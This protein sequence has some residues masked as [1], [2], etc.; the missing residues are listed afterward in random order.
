GQQQFAIQLEQSGLYFLN[1]T[2]DSGTSTQRVV[3]R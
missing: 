2:S 1:M 3:V